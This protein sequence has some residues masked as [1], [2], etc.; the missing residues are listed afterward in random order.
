MAG[1][2][3]FCFWGCW[4]KGPCLLN[5]NDF[6]YVITHIKQLIP[7]P[8]FLIIAG[9]NYYPQKV[10]DKD[11]DKD[12]NPKYYIIN[13]NHLRSGFE[14]LPMN[15]KTYII[16]GNHD[17]D[18]NTAKKI[19]TIQDAGPADSCEIMKLEKESVKQNQNMK[20]DSFIAEYFPDKNTS[21]IM[22]DTNLFDD[23]TIPDCYPVTDE[24]PIDDPIDEP[25][26]STFA[27]NTS[28]IDSLIT[29]QNVRIQK[30]VEQHQLHNQS[31]HNI[32]LIGHYPIVSVKVKKGKDKVEKDQPTTILPKMLQFFLYI[33]SMYQGET[34]K[35]TYLCADTHLYQKGTI[36]ISSTNNAETME[37]N[38]YIVGTGGAEL[39]KFNSSQLDFSFAVNETYS[40]EYK[41]TDSIKQHGYLK[42]NYI[43]QQFNFQFESIS[44]DPIQRESILPID[45]IQIGGNKSRRKSCQ[46]NNKESQKSGRNTSKKERRFS[47]KIPKEKKPKRNT[48]KNNHKLKKN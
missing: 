3:F 46:N 4:N 35:F 45:R 16:Y 47:R 23:S 14:C 42:V 36:K 11:K 28:T 31:N 41:I 48:S 17:L 26:M 2:L 7:P 44:R 21:I 10:K 33:R 6:Y 24:L 27:I 37:F 20:L 8:Q 15:I 13:K 38:Q 22:F 25:I 1:N 12:K 18:T 34:S 40:V 30:F 39:D 5:E 29:K 9:D 43:D 32:I 19:Y